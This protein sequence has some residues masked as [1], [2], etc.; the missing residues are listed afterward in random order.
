MI[1]GGKSATAGNKEACITSEPDRASFFAPATLE[2]S[3]FVYCLTKLDNKG[4]QETTE[5]NTRR[6][7]TLVQISTRLSRCYDS[8]AGREREMSSS[9]INPTAQKGPSGASLHTNLSVYERA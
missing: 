6:N 2:G 7:Q 3:A 4:S 5:P 8:Q 9:P 1:Q